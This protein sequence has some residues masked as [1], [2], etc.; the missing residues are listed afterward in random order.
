MKITGKELKEIFHLNDWVKGLGDDEVFLMYWE[1]G[2]EVLL[3]DTQG[4]EQF[5]F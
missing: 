2:V 1:P 5:R 4:N 3:S